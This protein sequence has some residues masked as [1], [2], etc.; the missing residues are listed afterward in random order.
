[1]KSIKKLIGKEKEVNFKGRLPFSHLEARN[2]RPEGISFREEVQRVEE[3]LREKFTYNEKGQLIGRRRMYEREGEIVEKVLS[4]IE[5]KGV[6]V[7]ER[8][9]K[10]KA[11]N[12]IKNFLKRRMESGETSIDDIEIMEEL[13]IP[14]DEVDEIMEELQ[15]EGFVKDKGF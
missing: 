6:F 10:D 1:M 14:I 2:F 13:K 12:D 7:L 3:I 11:K 4:R 8:K 9:D 5:D 15:E